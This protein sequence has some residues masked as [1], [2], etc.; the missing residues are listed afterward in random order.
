MKIEQY[1]SKSL[2]KS[3]VES[4]L[5]DIEKYKKALRLN[6]YFQKWAG[7]IVLRVGKCAF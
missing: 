5:Y 6:K 1:L 2:M 3:S 4:Y 7:D